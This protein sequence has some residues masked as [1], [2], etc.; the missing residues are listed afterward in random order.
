LHR[1]PVSYPDPMSPTSA[2]VLLVVAFAVVGLLGLRF[3]AGET[4]RFHEEHDEL[5]RRH[6]EVMDR[7]DAALG[8][9]RAYSSNVN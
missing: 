9:S 6:R 7:A 3:L 5:E 1:E 8:R 4:R 2:V